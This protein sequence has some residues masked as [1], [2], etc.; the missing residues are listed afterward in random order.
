M[1]IQRKRNEL[2]LQKCWRF[3]I[4]MLSLIREPPRNKIWWKSRQT[5]WWIKTWG[6]NG[7]YWQRKLLTKGQCG[8]IL[9]NS[10]GFWIWLKVPFIHLLLFEC[11]F[12]LTQQIL[13]DQSINRTWQKEGSFQTS[14]D[15]GSIFITS[16]FQSSKQFDSITRS[17]SG[18]KRNFA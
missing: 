18:C 12:L 9:K 8:Q 10:D 1:Y 7:K 6:C 15:L 11:V 2:I 14:C 17:N 5:S 13:Y 4:F 3:F 16:I